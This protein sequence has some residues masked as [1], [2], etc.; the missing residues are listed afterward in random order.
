MVSHPDPYLPPPPPMYAHAN[1]TQLPLRRPPSVMSASRASSTTS[2]SRRHHHHHS[3]QSHHPHSRYGRSHAGGGGGGSGGAYAPQNEFPIFSQSGDVE[4]VLRTRD[5]R[6]ETRYLLHRIY[7]AQSSGFFEAGTSEEWARATTAAAGGD[8]AGEVGGADGAGAEGGGRKL[9][10]GEVALRQQQQLAMAR[11]V[12][13]GGRRRWRYELDW[14]NGEDLPLLVQKDPSTAS[15]FGG[16]DYTPRPP[17]VRNKPPPPGSGFFRTMANFTTLHIASPHHHASSSSASAA[18]TSSSS[19]HSYASSSSSSSNADDDLLHTYDNLFRTFYNYPPALDAVNIAR[20]YVECKAL[21]RVA[22]MYD[23]LSVVGPRVDHHLLRFQGRLFKQIAKYP[24]SYLKLGY[25]ARS[26]VIFG[27]ALVHVVG[28]WP[29]GL[30]QLRAGQVPAA[31][32]DVIE[33]KVGELDEAKARV[34]QRLWRISLTTSRG[35]RVGPANAWLDWCALS[36]FRSWLAEATTPPPAGILKGGG[37]GSSAG[38]TAAGAARSHSRAPSVA[39]AAGGRHEHQRPSSSTARGSGGSSSRGG[40]AAGPP[41]PPPSSSSSPASGA[42]AAAG[43]SG[44]VFRLLGA[45][46]QAYLGRDE[47]KRFLKGQPGEVYSREALRRFER[48]VDEIKHLARDAVKPLM[49]NYLELEAGWAGGRGER[50]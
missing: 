14:G 1:T 19:S 2:H 40:R 24:P 4:I 29:A 34:E 35:E 39:S 12:E 22:D 10:G 3:S 48:R 31:V 5:G 41:P 43:N 49:R 45:G 47:L 13:A 11:E 33:D 6:R 32:L 44:R 50:A 9:V 21:L 17:P 28:M 25:L 38:S 26:R 42:A 36:L 8:G 7:L 23:A 15:L 20:A 18:G 30:P 46:G 16:S 27:E 37:G